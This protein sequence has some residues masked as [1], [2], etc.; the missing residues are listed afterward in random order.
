LIRANAAR[1]DTVF[2]MPAMP[3]MPVV[4]TTRPLALAL[5]L[6]ACFALSACDPGVPEAEPEPSV[7]VSE[8][9]SPS[10]SAS[11]E[12]HAPELSELVLTSNGMG[13][14]VIGEAPSTEPTQQMI[15]EDPAACADENTGFDAGVEPGDPDALRWVPIAEYN[16]ADGYPRWSV[17][18]IDGALMRID[19][20]DDS[21]PTDK[22]VRIGD[23]RASA[24]AAYPDGMLV[25]QTITDVLVV[26]GAHGVLHIEIAKAMSGELADYW[27]A[28]VDT[29]VFV[30]AVD[31][32]DGVFTVA[33]SENIAGGCL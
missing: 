5:A 23:S 10:P 31:L 17:S 13:T 8:E 4:R 20:H 25:D 7:S 22:G 18:V 26:P 29:V 21:I 27:G 16:A 24:L 1:A 30:R 3:A 11:E 32:A 9:P 19:L 2:A 6:V 15:E 28:Q 14:L 33:A 12:P